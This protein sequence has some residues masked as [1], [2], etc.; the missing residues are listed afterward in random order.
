[1]S[2]FQRIVKYSAIGLA[3]FLTV[4]ILTTVLQIVVEIIGGI[5][6]LSS[7]SDKDYTKEYEATEVTGFNIENAA[8]DLII[9]TGTANSVKVEAENV[10]ENFECKL[11]SDGTLKVDGSG[12]SFPF[13]GSKGAT[14]ITIYVPEGAQYDMVAIDNG[15]G[16]LRVN[17][18]TADDL[19]V[20]TGAGAFYGSNITSGDTKI[21]GGVGEIVLEDINFVDADIDLGVGST[22]LKGSI[23]GDS[24]FEC[25]VGELTA[26]LTGSSDLYDLKVE[27]GLGEIKINGES[28]SSVKWNSDTADNSLDIE[29]GVGSVNINFKE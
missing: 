28:Y 4:V 24:K 3:I 11:Q 6:G 7:G 5:S 27:K 18:L 1:M 22:T 17:D 19:K 14:T 8:G 25:G 2:S 9:K 16:T 26:D 13:I 12:W 20:S 10:N 29:G 15:A 21:D 23:T